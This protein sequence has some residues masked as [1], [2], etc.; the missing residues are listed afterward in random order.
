MTVFADLIDTERMK[1]LEQQAAEIRK[2][3]LGALLMAK[4]LWRKELEQEHEESELAR[5][6]REAEEA[7]VDVY[8]EDSSEKLENLFEI[9]RK[10]AKGL[11]R[12]M[13]AATNYERQKERGDY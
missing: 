11:F 2:L 9:I 4:D 8:R 1:G 10:R 12:I 3:L 13:E 5:A 7:F 6:I